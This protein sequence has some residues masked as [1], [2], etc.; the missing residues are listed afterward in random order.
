[1]SQAIKRVLITDPIDKQFVESLRGHGL[2]VNEK[3]LSKEQ[4]LVD[5]RLRLPVLKLIGRAGTGVDNIDVPAATKQGVLVMNT[6]GANTISAAEHTCALIL[7]LSRQIPQAQASLKAGRWDRKLFMGNEVQGKT[8]AILGLGRIGREVATR[9]KSFG[10]TVVGYDPVIPA[11]VIAEFGVKSLSLA[12]IWPVADYITVHVPLLP[13][14]E[15]LINLEVLKKCKKSVNIVNVARGGIVS[16]PDLLAALK[17]GLTGGAALDVFTEEPP[18]SAGLLEL[19]QHPKVI[20]TPHL[21]ASTVEAQE[22]VAADL[23]EQIGQFITTGK[24]A[25]FVNKI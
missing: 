3:K 11:N 25:G 18:V 16:E 8:L 14:T 10:M 12:E 21:G 2:E 23:A 15:N 17:E 20:C 22:R 24:A 1:M 19:L 9:M 13:E 7:A 6:P 5:C 4:L